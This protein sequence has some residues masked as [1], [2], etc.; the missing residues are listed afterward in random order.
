MLARLMLLMLLMWLRLL[1][2]FDVV[3]FVVSQCVCFAHCCFG[4][5]VFI[6]FWFVIGIEFVSFGRYM[7]CLFVCC[8]TFASV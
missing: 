5:L 2:L 4:L 1:M 3:D 8:F 7:F 6:R